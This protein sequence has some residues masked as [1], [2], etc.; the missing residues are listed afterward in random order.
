L[1]SECGKR[2]DDLVA[3]PSEK[4][5]GYLASWARSGQVMMGALIWSMT[6]GPQIKCRCEGATVDRREKQNIV[7]LLLLKVNPQID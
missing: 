2:L 1:C 6:D 5:A 4:V 3:D 7:L